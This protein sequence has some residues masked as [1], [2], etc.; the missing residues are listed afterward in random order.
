MEQ[1]NRPAEVIV[2]RITGRQG[3]IEIPHRYCEE[4]DLTVQVV[5]G[6]IDKLDSRAITL[7][8]RPWL[9]WFWKPLLRGGWHAPIVSVNGRIISQG[10]V[11][12]NEALLNAICSAQGAGQR[13]HDAS[14][15]KATMR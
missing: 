4:C 9:L 2:Y 10:I 1:T 14:H 6:V 3:I 11:P 13:E 8:I 7:T 12:S 15:P 5:R